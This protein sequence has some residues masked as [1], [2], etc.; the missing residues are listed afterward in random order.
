[1]DPRFDPATLLILGLSKLTAFVPLPC[2]SPTVTEIIRLPLAALDDCVVTEVSDVQVVPSQEVCP[3]DTLSDMAPFTKLPPRTVRLTE[4]VPCRFAFWTEL[5]MATSD[6]QRLDVLPARSP[7]VTANLRDDRSVLGCR[8]R[9]V[10]S[11]SHPVDSQLVPDT[12]MR[13]LDV[14]PPRPEPCTVRLADP[15]EAPLAL[16]LT[17]TIA[18]SAET[19]CVTL[20]TRD[21]TVTPTRRLPPITVPT[22]H[23]TALSDSHAVASQDDP[24]TRIDDVNVARPSPLPWIVTEDD[25]V[26]ARLDRLRR[27][28]GVASEDKAWDSDDKVAPAVTD[29]LEVRPIVPVT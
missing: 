13:P 26:A 16:S 1:M 29:T 8:P 11:E 17:L 10:E 21:P 28:T 18:T 15:V 14:H 27:L 6:D 2:F 22:E 7:D 19:L 3:T 24:C 5:M 25:P 12:L 23:R 4:P 20:E 9:T